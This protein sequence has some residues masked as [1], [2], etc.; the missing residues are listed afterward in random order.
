MRLGVHVEVDAQADARC[1]LHLRG[2]AADAMQLAL[3][4]HVEA[5]DALGERKLDLVAALADAGEHD[6][7]GIAF[8]CDHTLELAA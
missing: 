2:D 8:G 1:A 3:R 7:A 5:E 6:L 4:L